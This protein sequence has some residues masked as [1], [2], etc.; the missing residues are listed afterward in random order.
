V[1]AQ[2]PSDALPPPDVRP[3]SDV[4]PPSDVLP[5]SDAPSSRW[6]LPAISAGGVVGALLRYS[7]GL[8]LPSGAPSFPWATLLVNVG[9]G[10]VMGALAAV[11]AQ[12]PRPLLRA[13][14]G[15]GLLGGFTTFSTYSTDTYRLLEAGRAGQALVYAV[16]T[17]T[18]ALTAT[19]A[20][21]RVVQAFTGPGRPRW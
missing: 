3:S 15:V 8:M 12:R 2:P 1:S 21:R 20:G 16:G 7:V 17:L 19:E 6:L 18:L 11:L 9:G 13:F 5:P 10:F 14:A 4:R